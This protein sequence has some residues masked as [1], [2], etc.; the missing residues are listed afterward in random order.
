MVKAELVKKK[1][2]KITALNGVSFDTENE[3]FG[4]IGPD[5]AGKTTLFRI[6]TTLLLA[7]E[8]TVTI[9]GYDVVKDYT[10]IRKCVGYMPGKFSLYQ[11][12]SVEENINFFATIFGTTLSENYRFIKE[13]YSQIEPFKDRRADALS[14][15]MKQELA[16]SCALV[17]RPQVLFL[18]EPTTGV[19]PV[20][21]REFWDMLKRLK[22]HGITIIVSTPYMDEAN[23]CDRIALIKDGVFL[24]INTPKKIASEFKKAL[25]AIRAD[26]M[27]KL[28]IDLRLYPHIDSCFAFGDTHHIT[29]K[30]VPA[31]IDDVPRN[32]N[33]QPIQKYLQNK[34]HS[35]IEIFKIKPGIEDCFM[36]L[37]GD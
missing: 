36:T 10:H 25:Y 12:L 6:M 20:S 7:D 1:Y 14:G 3:I 15:G 21:R 29:F 31:G 27:S 32:G 22:D 24:N 4:I 35:N 34:G 30:N 23:M 19:D 37:A 17:H 18:D 5:G 9:Q 28:L 13:I 26:N 2:D 8:G 11:D 33:F 16:L